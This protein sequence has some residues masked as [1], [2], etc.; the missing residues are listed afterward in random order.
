MATLAALAAGFARP[1]AILTTVN[2]ATQRVP[3]RDVLRGRELHRRRSASASTSARCARYLARM[4]FQ[5]APTVT[6]PGEFAIRGGL[7]DLFPPGARGAGPARPLRRRARQRPPLRPRDPAHHRDGEARRARAGL[8]GHPRR[9]RRSSASAPATATHVRRRRPRR[10]ALRGD[11]RRP[12]AP[13]LRA[14]A[15]V[16]PRAARDALRLPP[17]RAGPPRR[18]D[19]RRPR[20]PL[21]RARRP[22]RRPRRSAGGEVEARHRLQAGA[23][24]ARSTSTTPP[25]TRPSPAARCTS[26]PPCRSRSAPASSTPA[27]ASAATSPPSASRSS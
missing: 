18:P 14:L 3:A 21:G 4:G 9:R 16:L 5:Q 2:A 15:A 24:R 26:S 12:Q 20:R 22:V 10:P 17:R 19:R 8:R 27:A 13:G 11:Q 6:E 1:A 7:I 23:R 25:G